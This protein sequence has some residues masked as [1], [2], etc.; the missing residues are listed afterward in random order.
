MPKRNSRRGHHEDENCLCALVAAQ[1]WPEVKDQL[2]SSSQTKSTCTFNSDMDDATFG[3]PNTTG[4]TL[5]DKRNRNSADVHMIIC[6]SLNNDTLLHC[7]CRNQPPLEIVRLVHEK[8]PKLISIATIKEKHYPVDLACMYGAHPMV[9]S[10]LVSEFPSAASP[11]SVDSEGRTSLHLICSEYSTHYKVVDMVV[12]SGINETKEKLEKL[13]N[14]RRKLRSNGSADIIHARKPVI[15]SGK[16]YSAREAM[17]K[18]VR[19]LTQRFPD[20]VVVNDLDDMTALEHAI[21]GNFHID[22]VKSLQRA[23][24]R[25]LRAEKKKQQNEESQLKSHD[26]CNINNDACN[27][28]NDACDIN[29][30]ARREPVPVNTVQSENLDCSSHE[31][32]KQNEEKTR[33]VAA[34]KHESTSDVH[35]AEEEVLIME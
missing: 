21:C 33:R 24:E 32:A 14:G 3:V 1:N 2:E 34:T 4:E 13:G 10:Y 7:I 35:A 22:I 30:D 5:S 17:L 20:I 8:Y 23:G 25:H 19:I 26:A 12:L 9:I 18:S 31:N 29:N 16:P 27:I 11:S 28:N 6:D 15:S